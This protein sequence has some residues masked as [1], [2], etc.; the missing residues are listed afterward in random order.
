MSERSPFPDNNKFK[1]QETLNETIDHLL[2]GPG[3]EEAHSSAAYD[4]SPEDLSE[5]YIALSHSL[6]NAAPQQGDELKVP[7]LD[8]RR[9][10]KFLVVDEPYRAK[11]IAASQSTDEYGL[12]HPKSLSI[13]LFYEDFI[14]STNEELISVIISLKL[15]CGNRFLF[16][17]VSNCPEGGKG[18]CEVDRGL[19]PEEMSDFVEL[20]FQFRQRRDQ[21]D[22]TINYDNYGEVMK[23]IVFAR[24]NPY[25]NHPAREEFIYN[26]VIGK[27]VSSIDERT[28][29][30]VI[31]EA[32]QNYPQLWNQ[33]EDLQG[34]ARDNAFVRLLALF[35]IEVM[36]EY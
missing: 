34:N 36:D 27:H 30:E 31:N 3:Q 32:I 7:S 20:A 24:E 13:N 15:L 8:G 5:F 10:E 26:P 25:S 11:I 35:D 1:A 9:Y 16:R 6:P 17:E 18:I 21:I 23:R 2:D 14:R 28:I 12:N 4:V 22:K 29:D 19:T 33:L